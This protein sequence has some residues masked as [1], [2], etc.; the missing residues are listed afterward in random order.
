MVCQIRKKSNQETV[1]T[2]KKTEKKTDYFR[3]GD[4]N[5]TGVG[6]RIVCLCQD[7]KDEF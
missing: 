3:P 7:G 1:E 6:G 4:C 2:S 5:I